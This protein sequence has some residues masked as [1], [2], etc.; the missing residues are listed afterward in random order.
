MNETK[1]RLS[2]WTV[3]SIV[4]TSFAAGLL[5]S[6][7]L[8]IWMFKN[9]TTIP[10]TLKNTY[11]EE[12]DLTEFWEVYS[13]LKQEY[14][15]AEKVKKEDLQEWI[16]VGLV[17][18][19]GDK[20]SEFM[21]PEVNKKFQEVLSGDFE[22]IG[23]VVEKV[24][25]GVKVE[26]ILKWSPAKKAGVFSG[27]IIIEANGNKLEWVDL[28]DAV[29]KIK[30]DAGT[31]ALLKIIR[32]GELDFLE[33]SVTREKIILPSIE[34]EVFEENIWYIAINMYGETTSQEFIKALE[35][36]QE[37]KVQK[38]I[39]DVRDNGGGYLQSAVE[40]LS[41]IIPDGEVL[42]QT[43][44]R[45]SVF[46]KNYYSSNT[47]VFEW[48][49]VILVNGNSASA[50]EITAGAL[51][52]YNK[53]IVVWEK[54]YG[55][56]SVQQPFDMKSGSLLKLTIANWYTPKGK[57]IEGDGI[58]PDIEILFEKEDYENQYDRQLEE[59]KKIV[60]QFQEVGSLQLTIDQYNEK[61]KK[62]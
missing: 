14:Y 50:S 42:V 47:G 43:K 7:Y 46:N 39:I 57:S 27:D 40:I 48:K 28:Y 59:A 35:E 26:R 2:F 20:H 61:K 30:G 12:L 25:L 58:T 52:E 62:K 19:L 13:I 18:S 16:I 34:S 24:P 3:F 33:I 17:E 53:A 5:F 4:L 32:Q 54:T 15:S 29:D 31:T 55:K 56:W 6:H 36:L 37:S 38:L 22:G 23:A 21:N 11:K 1:K 44:Y 9:P 45:D 8:G 41:K 51:R 10:E 60:K 49:I